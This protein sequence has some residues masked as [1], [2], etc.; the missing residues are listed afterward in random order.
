MVP[1]NLNWLAF[2]EG[3]PASQ[4]CRV[5]VPE[6]VKNLI[7]THHGEAGLAEL[8]AELQGC[9]RGT[10]Q[11]LPTEHSRVNHPV[12]ARRPVHCAPSSRR[13]GRA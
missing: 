4:C 8:T 2:V 11:P 5:M 13:F 7:R 6:E 1:L 10:Q 12:V 9:L 3:V